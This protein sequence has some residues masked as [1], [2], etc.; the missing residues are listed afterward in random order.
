MAMADIRYFTPATDPADEYKLSKAS[1]NYSLGGDVCGACKHWIEEAEDE[2]TET[3]KCQLVRGVIG[4]HMWCRL[5]N[6][7]R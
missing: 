6:R 2:E 1:V 7:R 4:E 5:F 3:G